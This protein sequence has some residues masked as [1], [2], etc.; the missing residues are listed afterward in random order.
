[1]LFNNSTAMTGRGACL[2]YVRIVSLDSQAAEGSVAHVED[3]EAALEAA[4]AASEAIS[5][6]A[7]VEV[8]AAVLEE[9]HVVDLEEDLEAKV[10]LVAMAVLLQPQPHQM[11]SPTSQAR[12]LTEAKSSSFAM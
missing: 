3:S 7:A 8:S 10:A 1:M 4:V 12:G 6:A 5:V 2:K 11:L 9:A